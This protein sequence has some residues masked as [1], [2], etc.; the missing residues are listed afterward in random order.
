MQ[1]KQCEL[2]ASGAIVVVAYAVGE[3]VTLAPICRDK[4]LNGTIIFHN[5]L[6]AFLL[7]TRH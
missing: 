4:F 6:Q 7:F 5:S 1:E 3:D 2:L